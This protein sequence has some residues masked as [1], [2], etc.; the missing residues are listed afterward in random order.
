VF[1]VVSASEL[2]PGATVLCIILP[3]ELIL[4][5]V[6]DPLS[7][8]VI[9]EKCLS[10]NISVSDAVVISD[11]VPLAITLTVV[12]H[13]I[14]DDDNSDVIY[15]VVV[16]VYDNSDVI[17]LVVVVGYDNSN[18]IDVVVV[19]DF[20]QCDVIYLLVVV[21]F[22]NCDS[23]GVDELVVVCDAVT[24]PISIGVELSTA[25]VIR[26]CESLHFDVSIALNVRVRFGVSEPE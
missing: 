13:D 22:D 25:I 26:E 17:Y 14:I 7:L 6:T 23:V 3:G 15:L 11:V 10:V 12:F 20:E 24:V 9:D 1:C 4:D 8:T 21:D 2:Y 18:V 16:V 19:V 5:A